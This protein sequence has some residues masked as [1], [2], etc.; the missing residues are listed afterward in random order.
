MIDIIF[1][2]LAAL[3]LPVAAIVITR[4]VSWS[5]DRDIEQSRRQRLADGR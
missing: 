5:L 1:Y 2:V 3:T 4:Y